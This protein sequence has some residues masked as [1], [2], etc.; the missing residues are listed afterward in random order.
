[1]QQNEIKSVDLEPSVQ[2]EN[3]VENTSQDSQADSKAVEDK[4]SDPS[5][6]I[7]GKFKSA[8]D[9]AHAYKELEKLQGNQSSE[10]GALREKV[11]SMNSSN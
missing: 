10:L 9:L 1:M 3:S 2:D 5:A 6:L 11:A 8:E 7:L 4:S